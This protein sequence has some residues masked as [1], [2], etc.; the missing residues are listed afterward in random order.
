MFC[1]LKS[2]AI[3]NDNLRGST[4]DEEVLSFAEIIFS[5]FSG[6]TSKIVSNSKKMGV[7]EFRR[8]V[9]KTY[10]KK[11][12]KNQRKEMLILHNGGVQLE[13]MQ[14]KHINYLDKYYGYYDDLNNAIG[15]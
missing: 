11:I 13:K 1:I 6:G 3:T 15:D 9:S 10:S 7:D 14:V 12:T 2:V 8:Y 4:I 5:I